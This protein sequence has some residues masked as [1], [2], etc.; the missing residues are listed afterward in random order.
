MASNT[1]LRIGRMEEI[2]SHGMNG[3]DCYSF[4]WVKLNFINLVIEL[5]STDRLPTLCF[6]LDR[7]ACEELFLKLLSDLE[8]LEDKKKQFEMGQMNNKEM[9]IER[10]RREKARQKLLKKQAK[11]R[12]TKN[13]QKKN[14]DSNPELHDGL[15]EFDDRAAN[16]NNK[17]DYRF[18]LFNRG[19][20][21]DSDDLKFW[22]RRLLKKTKWP[23]THPLMRGLERGIGLHHEGLPL[24]YRQ[25][26]ETL[27]RA[28]HIKLVVSVASLAMGVNMP[29]RCVV[30][31]GDS[32]QLDPLNYRQMMG[33]AGRRGY[34]NIGHVIFFGISPRKI[35][36]LM[37]SQLTSLN[38]HYPIISITSSIR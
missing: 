19:D 36:Y 16:R 26:V 37:T 23:A 12:E 5:E 17:K 13:R 8:Y 24:Q 30:F 7:V 10:R 33:R 31:A 18:A 38:G 6:V 15:D 34:D 35:S 27:F 29:A 20:E 28:K 25:L 32:F 3:N 1:L 9:E 22:T 4:E 11:L 21:M 2:Q 14:E